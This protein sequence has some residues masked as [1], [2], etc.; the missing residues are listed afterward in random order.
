MDDADGVVCD[1]LLLRSFVIVVTSEDDV[2]DGNDNNDRD[3]NVSY[4]VYMY[5]YISNVDDGWTQ[6]VRTP[7]FSASFVC[8][9]SFVRRSFVVRSLS[10]E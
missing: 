10:S 2:T 8:S 4:R 6:A 7:K 1:N 5:M 3:V 9:L